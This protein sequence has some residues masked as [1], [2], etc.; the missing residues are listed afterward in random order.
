L[1]GFRGFAL[2]PLVTLLAVLDKR[3][4]RL[5]KA[6]FA[7][8]LMVVL[9]AIPAVRIERED[10]LAKRSLSD[11]AVASHPLAALQE[12]GGSLRPLVHTLE[13]L[14][15]EDLRWGSTYMQALGLIAP[16]LSLEWEGE[17]YIAVENLPPSHWVSKLAAPWSYRNYGGLG[18]S[19]IAEPYMN[20][21]T[22]GVALFFLALGAAL[23]WADG[24]DAGRPTRLACWA[25]ALG[26]LLWTTRNTS[27][28]FFRPA[29]WGLLAVGAARL[30]SEALA[31]R[32]PR[33]SN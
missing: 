10:P 17:S 8:A 9:L 31:R 1:L 24:I 21:G 11:L 33:S 6:A 7:G 19:A 28:V 13:L 20:F 12:M 26:P 27:A 29:L 14:G 23:V 18:F 32:E 22:A 3:G 16:N 4:M 30:L 5:P 25:M 2:V 15:D